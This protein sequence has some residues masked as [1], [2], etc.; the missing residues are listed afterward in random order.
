M[1]LKLLLNSLT[2]KFF[3][4]NRSLEEKTFLL[5]SFSGIFM[6]AIGL[7]GNISLHLSVV[8]LIIPSINI[9]IDCICI[10]YFAKTGKWKV[11]SFIVI[12]YAIFVLFPSLWF[13]T[14]GATGST[15]PFVVLVGIFVVIAFKGKF[16][17]AILVIVIVM[18]AAFTILEL[19]FPEITTQYPDRKSHYIDLSLGMILSYSVSVYLAYQVLSD[20]EKSRRESE[21]LVNQLE[22]S[23]VTD[24]LTGVYNRRFL[25]SCLDEEMRKAYDSGTDLSICIIDIDHFK[26]INDTY[27]HSF[28]DEVLVKLSAHITSHLGSNDV[29]G[30][31]GGEEFLIIFKNDSLSA[32]VAKMDA[33]CENLKKVQWRNNI[34]VTISGGISTYHKGITFS[35]ILEA[36]DQALYRAKQNGRDQVVY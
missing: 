33:V 14:N 17:A 10:V 6:S 15:M 16:R 4:R 34:N 11:P 22:I 30:R 32:A 18:F 5:V 23:S 12:M 1:K 26:S 13:S 9:I 8:T 21:K 28:G 27:G 24:A 35:K 25:T 31:Y 36:A 7:A 19:Y 20:Y 2:E 3:T 29:F